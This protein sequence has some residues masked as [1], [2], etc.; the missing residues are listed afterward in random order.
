[1]SMADHFAGMKKNQTAGKSETAETFSRTDYSPQAQ[2]SRLAARV[3][4]AKLPA[5]RTAGKSQTSGAS[6]TFDTATTGI[7][8]MKRR[9]DVPLGDV[10]GKVVK[11]GNPEYR[12]VTSY[13]RRE[14]TARALHKW[15]YE[16]GG[17]FSDL[18]EHLLAQ[19]LG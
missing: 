8:A 16:D 6:E 18:I 13:L 11:K 19:Y 2:A 3:A 14:T 1:M 10:P 9:N 7:P 12:Q 17:D 15:R 5:S 4:K